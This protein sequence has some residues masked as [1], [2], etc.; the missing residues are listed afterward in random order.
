[1]KYKLLGIA[2][3]VCCVVSI[4]LF[5]AWTEIIFLI[6]AVVLGFF[7][8]SMISED[9]NEE[10]GE[11]GK[12]DGGED[13]PL[14]R[15][16]KPVGGGRRKTSE[17]LL[18]EFLAS[19]KDVEDKFEQKFSL[20]EPY[21]YYNENKNFPRNTAQISV[22]KAWCFSSHSSLSDIFYKANCDSVNG[23]LIGDMLGFFN[24]RVSQQN[25]KA[26]TFANS[27]SNRL[28]LY[29][30]QR[31]FPGLDVVPYP[32]Y[33]DS[34]SEKKLGHWVDVEY[35]P[36]DVNFLCKTYS[37]ATRM[38]AGE[39]ISW[40]DRMSGEGVEVPAM[41]KLGTIFYGRYRNNDKTI[42]RYVIVESVMVSALSLSGDVMPEQWAIVLDCDTLSELEEIY[43]VNQKNIGLLFQTERE[44]KWH[45]ASKDELCSVVEKA[46]SIDSE[47]LSW[48]DTLYCSLWHE[49]ENLK[50]S[51]A[52]YSSLRAAYEKQVRA[53]ELE[54]DEWQ[55]NDEREEDGKYM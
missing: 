1:M 43:C 4:I 18:S 10:E 51:D 40:E 53:Q 20:G 19:V 49:L 5:V 22:V 37:Q 44:L 41:F 45:E 42:R 30:D 12:V 33:K 16:R 7:C 14:A 13:A 24:D 28:F 31:S 47:A 32:V 35:G 15:N 23:E 39:K 29:F 2:C 36:I 55:Q 17:D 54:E 38:L 50:K 52:K 26:C 48:E 3:G 46:S 25:A 11:S 6:G 9:E 34:K 27:Q 21:Y 8:Y